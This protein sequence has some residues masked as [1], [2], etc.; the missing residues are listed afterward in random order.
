MVGCQD[1]EA[2][3]KL[4]EFKAQAAVEEQNK[5]VVRRMFEAWDNGDFEAVKDLMSP[6]FL[7]Y[8]PA[9]TSEPRSLEEHLE[10]GQT[11][12]DGFPDNTWIIE[13]LISERNKI[14]VRY[15]FRGT[16]LGEFQGRPA[17][18]NFQE[19]SG[20]GF[21]TVENGKIVEAKEEFDELNAMLFLGYELKPKE[22]K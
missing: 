10:F 7:F 8:T 12:Q 19:L 3:A 13:E 6:E 22:E 4:E 5:E 20:M 18:G 2:M 1:K 9:I 15:I 16:H 21:Y 17:T 11:L 14:A